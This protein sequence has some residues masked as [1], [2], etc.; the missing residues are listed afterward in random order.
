MPKISVHIGAGLKGRAPSSLVLN[1]D[2]A[3]SIQDLLAILRNEY[4]LETSPRVEVPGIESFNANMLVLLNG[5]N[6]IY[7]DGF[8][9]KLS[10]GDQINFLVLLVGG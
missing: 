4:A 5:R 3:S 6:I 1:V 7:Y 10:E 2:E 8:A 9:T